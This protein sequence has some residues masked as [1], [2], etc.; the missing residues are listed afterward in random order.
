MPNIPHY[1]VRRGCT[2]LDR[3][4]SLFDADARS[5]WSAVLIGG[6][7]K[8]NEVWPNRRTPLGVRPL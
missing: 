5:D 1:R 8:Q 4:A 2:T 3:H 7:K 6:E